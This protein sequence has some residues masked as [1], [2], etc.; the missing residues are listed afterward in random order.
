MNYRKVV[1]AAILIA[2]TVLFSKKSIAQSSSDMNGA[3]FQ[4][5][6]NYT[7][8]TSSGLSDYLV[9]LSDSLQFPKAFSLDKGYGI[10]LAF[11]K[12][13][14][15]FEFTAGGDVIWSNNYLSFGDTMSGRVS[16]TDINLNFGV[17][18]LP[19]HWFFIGG[20][21]SICNSA[22]KFKGA[23]HTYSVV[24]ESQED[25]LSNMFNGYS[26]GVK[27]QAGFNINVSE[28]GEYKTYMR[29][30]AFY[31][32]G[33]TEFNFYK[34]FENRMKYFSGNKK[35]KLAYPG[36]TLSLQFKASE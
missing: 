10:T 15:A 24:L 21:F 18:V 30:S 9:V 7:Q 17:N 26:V 19:V 2:G 31:E 5:G 29:L 33:L 11:I 1:S 23:D 16:S 20:N 32:L 6:I 27:G 25:G 36:V 34:T 28:K 22:E 8:P 4:I 14:N 35:T 3:F 13:N 12:H